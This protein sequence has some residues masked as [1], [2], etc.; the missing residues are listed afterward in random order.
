MSFSRYFVLCVNLCIRLGTRSAMILS[1]LHNWSDCV[2]G[3]S[4]YHRVQNFNE[5]STL[6]PNLAFMSAAL[7]VYT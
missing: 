6:L 5:K 2:E 1:F 4:C 3:L 7:T